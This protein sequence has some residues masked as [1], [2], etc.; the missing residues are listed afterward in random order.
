MTHRLFQDGADRRPA[1]GVG[2]GARAAGRDAGAAG[3]AA[4]LHGERG[5][6][7]HGAAR[8]ARRARDGRR[9]R[10]RPLWL[11]EHLQRQVAARG[12]DQARPHLHARVDGLRRDGFRIYAPRR[13]APGVERRGARRRVQV[14]RHAADL[15][16]AL[17]HR[18]RPLVRRRAD[19]VDGQRPPAGR[20][21]PRPARL[22]LDAGEGGGHEAQGD[23]ALP[24]RHVRVLGRRDAGRAHGQGLPL[25]LGARVPGAC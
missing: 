18:G 17:V 20:L 12:R 23:H 24:A 3:D 5:A 6:A 1:A 21:R 7:L 16:L 15:P 25:L 9:R 8:V 22:L 2:L 10:L 19:D 13:H 4:R 14:R 11:L